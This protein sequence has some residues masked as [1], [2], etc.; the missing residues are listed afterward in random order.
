[1]GAVLR[2]Q[3][4]A[5]VISGFALKAG[6]DPKGDKYSA[7]LDKLPRNSD[8]LLVPN[9]ENG[10]NTT[11]FDRLEQDDYDLRL[12]VWKP[13]PGADETQIVYHFYPNGICVVQASYTIARNYDCDF[14]QNEAHDLLKSSMKAHED[15]LNQLL[16]DLRGRIPKEYLDDGEA[17]SR[18]TDEN[19]SWVS[20]AV[21]L[22]PSLR[23]DP[24]TQTFIRN[25]LKETVD[26]ED[27][28]HII[29][30]EA[31][32]SVSWVNYFF[33][34][35]DR[36][37]IEDDLTCVRLAQCFFAAQYELN[38]QTQR[39]IVEAT[40]SSKEIRSAKAKLSNARERMQFLHIQFRTNKSFLRRSRRRKL[41]DI[42]EAWEFG[43]L[44]R[45]GEKMIESCTDKI[46]EITADRSERS[47]VMTDLILAFLALFTVIDLALSLISYSRNLMS[48]PA[49]NYNDDR[50]SWILRFFASID[51]DYVLTGGVISI[52]ILAGIYAYWKIER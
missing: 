17:P 44:V 14:L 16:D 25:W 12:L 7:I 23:S 48:N 22:D 41:D 42:L 43:E 21:I 51:T 11:E 26:Y 27:A 34:D 18:M 47:A 31:D 46:S 13:A 39:A 36:V 3:T 6:L 15:D 20:R 49:L 9:R 45:N 8:T 35:T 1:M 28:E 10:A 50:V 32:S 4:I 33:F 38:R 24:Q 19:I 37:D 30:G 52:L 29:S 5:P 2:L 40:F